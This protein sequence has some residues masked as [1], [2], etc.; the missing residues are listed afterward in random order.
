[1]TMEEWAEKYRPPSLADV[2]GNGAALAELERWARSWEG[3][4]PAKRAVILA[5]DP[6]VGKTSAALA[7]ARD[8]GWTVLEMNAS[9]RRNAAAIREVA[10]RGAL[11]QTF[12]DAG[13]YLR[14]DEGGRKLIVLDEADN[15]FGREDAGGVGAIVDTIRQAR[16]PIV[17]IV[18]DLY[19]LTRRSSAIKRLAKTIRFQAVHP[20]SVKVAL[21]RICKA[22]GLRVAD[23]VLEHIAERAG[24]DLRSAVNDLQSLAAG[25]TAIAEADLTV[26]GYRDVPTTIFAA[27]S[28]IF[29]SGHGER[30][31]RAVFDLDESPE[32]LVLWIDEN[33]P[34]EYRQPDDLVRGYDALTRADVFLGRVRR[35]QHYGL[36][37]Y[38]SDLMT[39]GVAVA[40][41]GRYGG[42]RYRFPLWLSKM[43][44]SRGRRGTIQGLCR[45]IGR[46][47]HASGHDVR[48]DLLPV[49]RFLFQ[50]DPTFRLAMALRLDLTEREVAFLLDR[51]EDARSVRRLLEEVAR[52]REGDAEGP[53][54]FARFDV[55]EG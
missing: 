24:G 20:A 1:M 54:L 43:S 12:T 28:E 9:D 34:F 31:R 7:L 38:A 18:N 36:W 51:K 3:G 17:L 40:R 29:R 23:G 44:R 21:Q 53:R 6:G 35:R 48:L 42:G 46:Y 19:E 33:M 39:A 8:M 4:V 32:D 41:R 2:V 11:M 47:V 37:S 49:F 25:R 45:K 10:T 5:G 22:E 30:A 55:P 14:A 16:Q 15:L 52:M 50:Q 13:A 26:L 27:L